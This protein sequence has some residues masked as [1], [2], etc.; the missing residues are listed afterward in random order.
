MSRKI[1]EGI[2]EPAERRA[3]PS[4]RQRNLK[5]RR[6]KMATMA[7]NNLVGVLRGEV[8]PNGES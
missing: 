8:P 7:A 3:L 6:D 4:H 5:R 1:E 2:D